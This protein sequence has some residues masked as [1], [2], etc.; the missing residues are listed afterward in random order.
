MLSI[1]LHGIRIVAPIG[2]YPEEKINPNTFET[3]VDVW[4]EEGA[5]EW[6]FVDYAIIHD[7]VADIFSQPAEMLETL[8]QHIHAAV[9]QRFPQ[10]TKIRVA[11]RKLNPP[12]SHEVKYSQVTYEV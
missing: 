8:V 12:L 9:K 3:D 1:S 4:V 7:I 10:S 11:V 2:M 6:P 5:G